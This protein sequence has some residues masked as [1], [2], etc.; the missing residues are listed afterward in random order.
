MCTFAHCQLVLH[1]VLHTVKK[2]L[3]IALH[4]VKQ[5]STFFCVP[6]IT[7]QHFHKDGKILAIQPFPDLRSCHKATCGIDI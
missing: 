6:Q 5:M 2:W 4:T 3:H 1:I 7:F